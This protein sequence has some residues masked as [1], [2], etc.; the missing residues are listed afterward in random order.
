MESCL[1][2]LLPLLSRERAAGRAVALAVLTQTT[3]STY[4]RPGALLLIA[5][6]GEYAGLISG[7]CLEGDLAEQARAVIHSGE[8]REIVYDLRDPNDL[9]WGIGSGCEGAMRILLLRVGPQERW[10]PLAHLTESLASHSPTAIA[11]VAASTDERVAL[12]SVALPEEPTTH[13]LTE[14]ARAALAAASRAHE[15]SWF[16]LSA[17]YRLF[18][19]PLALPPRLLV[20][21]AGPDAAPL[22]RLAGELRWKVTLA[23]HRAALAIPARFPTAERVVETRPESLHAVVDL[24]AF[25]AAVI[26]THQLELDR[27]YLR[28]LAES[29]LPYIG[30]LGPP[31][32]AARLLAELGE[33]A[34][35]LHGRLRAPVGLHLGG[36]SPEA[37]A[38]AIVA[39]ILAFLN[40]RLPIAAP[41]APIVPGAP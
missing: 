19:L 33:Q 30:L 7:G 12:G 35:M 32:R 2:A 26:M 34:S 13:W 18:L 29:A 25:D 5:A 3:G 38:V 28:V 15:P 20:L 27:A 8:A 10:Q 40:G 22:A 39:E 24:T 6:N 16:D 23:D 14:P 9:V 17:R 36:R 37:I 41:F 1:G 4:Q 31:A 11:L 21:G